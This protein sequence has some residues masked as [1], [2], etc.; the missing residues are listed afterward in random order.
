[1]PH[2]NIIALLSI[3]L[4]VVSVQSGHLQIYGRASADSVVS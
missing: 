1:M 3:D 4:T 2:E